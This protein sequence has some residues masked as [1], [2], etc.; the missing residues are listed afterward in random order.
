MYYLLTEHLYGLSE[1][2]SDDHYRIWTKAEIKARSYVVTKKGTI[3]SDQDVSNPEYVS[4]CLFELMR[5]K[6]GGIVYCETGIGKEAFID[7]L[8]EIPD[9]FAETIITNPKVRFIDI[10]DSNLT[11][12][13]LYESYL[14]RYGFCSTRKAF[15]LNK[16]YTIMYEFEFMHKPYV[17]LARGLHYWSIPLSEV[18]RCKRVEK[19]E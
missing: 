15:K 4:D 6:A 7:Y 16:Q 2:H 5:S 14:Q 9:T 13:E 19:K 10:P 3:F 18:E 11:L 12:G 8:L 17:V 1:S